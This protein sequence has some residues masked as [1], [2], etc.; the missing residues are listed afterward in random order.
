MYEFRQV[1]DKSI[2]DKHKEKFGDFNDFPPNW[3]EIT[4]EEF[5]RSSFFIYSPIH[6]EYRQMHL[7]DKS[8]V[9]DVYNYTPA[10]LC[11]MSDGTGYGIQNDFQ[12]GKVRYYKFAF[13]LHEF[14]KDLGKYRGEHI[15][16][17]KK[18]GY[19]YE[20]DSSD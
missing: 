18:C 19:R 12:N 7:H 13:C 8:G 4:E 14:G 1:I 17:C 5:A 20:Y 3:K 11:F 2:L 16:I 10:R 6:T 15:F 9:K